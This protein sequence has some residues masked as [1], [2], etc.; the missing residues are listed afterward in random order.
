[1]EYRQGEKWILSDWDARLCVV[2]CT[3]GK[4]FLVSRSSQSRVSHGSIELTD[5]TCFPLD[6][7]VPLVTNSREIIRRPLFAPYTTEEFRRVAVR[8]VKRV[9]RADCLELPRSG[10]TAKRDSCE[11]WTEKRSSDSEGNLDPVEQRIWTYTTS[12]NTLPSQLSNG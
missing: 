9:C 5:F 4:I 6:S 7:L 12:I 3:K 2:N 1:M 10:C 8:T 11:S